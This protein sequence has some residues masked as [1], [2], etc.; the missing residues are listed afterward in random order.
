MVVA[1]TIT[2]IIVQ[3]NLTSCFQHTKLFFILWH[4][5]KTSTLCP[6]GSALPA[7]ERGGQPERELHLK[8]MERNRRAAYVNLSY[9]DNYSMSL[10]TTVIN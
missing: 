8:E 6:Q 9:G 4:S 5:E 2:I 10:R 7:G 3:I 1:I